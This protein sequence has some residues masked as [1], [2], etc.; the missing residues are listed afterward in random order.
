MV[1]VV[2]ILIGVLVFQ[3]VIGLIVG[4]IFKFG[5]WP[6][7]WYRW[8]SIPYF[9]HGIVGP[10]RM[11]RTHI[12]KTE[13]INAETP[14]MFECEGK[15]T[16]DKENALNSNGRDYYVHNYDD[17]NP[18][19]MLQWEAGAVVFNATEIMDAF[20]REALK[21]MHGIG[22]KNLNFFLFAIF[23]IV[24]IALVVT[25]VS[26]YF[27]YNVYCGLNPHSCSGGGV[28]VR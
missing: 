9:K 11:P 17:F 14:P 16:I 7:A 5:G 24:L 18:I 2:E 4:L 15:R 26:V 6:E 21:D 19:P 27:S 13:I 22:K 20:E 10:D 28:Q 12:H 3:L 25:I 23:A 8:R 1:D